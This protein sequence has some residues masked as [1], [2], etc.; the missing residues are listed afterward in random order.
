MIPEYEEWKKVR[1]EIHLQDHWASYWQQQE[2][3]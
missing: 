2:V 1:V 3:L